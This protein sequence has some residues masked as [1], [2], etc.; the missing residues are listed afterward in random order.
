MRTRNGYVAVAPFP[1]KGIGTVTGKSGMAM[2]D[3]KVELI[4]TT[5]V[6]SSGMLMDQDNRTVGCYLYPEGGEVWLK[7]DAYQHGNSSKVMEV[8]PGKP[9]LLLPE[10][11]VVL[12][13]PR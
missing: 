8:E 5:I 2:A 1:T 7:A 10:E 3:R 9:F 6:Y 11:L 12:A 4:R 13:G